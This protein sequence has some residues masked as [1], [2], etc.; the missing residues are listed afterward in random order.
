MT[1]K[2]LTGTLS[3]KTTN[4]IHGKIM[5]I[6]LKYP[7]FL[8][9]PTGVPVYLAPWIACPSGGKPTVVS[10]PPR[11]ASCPGISYPPPWLSSAP[12]GASCPGRFILPPPI[13]KI[14]LCDVYYYLQ[15]NILRL[16]FGIQNFW[17]ETDRKDDH[18]LLL[19]ITTHD[20]RFAKFV[21]RTFLLRCTYFCAPNQ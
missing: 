13:Q 7:P 10:L 8:A 6:I 21:N 18:V 14:L 17:S 2:L 9:Y 1:E 5:K 20:T 19:N 12:G 11:G 16:G 3:L 4:Q 15:P